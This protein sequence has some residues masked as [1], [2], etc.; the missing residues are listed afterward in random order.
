MEKRE[1]VREGKA[2]RV[3]ATDRP[4]RLILEF[5]DEV[6][7]FGGRKRGVIPGKGKVNAQVSDAVFRHLAKRGIRTHHVELLSENEVLVWKLEMIPLEVAV[8]NYAAGSLAGRL[9]YPERTELRSPLLEY[10]YKNDELGDPLL[11][12]EHIRELGLATDDQLEEMAVTALRVNEI[13][14]PFFEARGLVL[15]DL[16]LEFGLREGRLHLGDELSPDVCRLWDAETGESMDKDRFRRDLGGMEEAYAEVLRR[17]KEEEKGMEVSVFITPKKGVLDP[18]GQATLG[19]LKS[20]GFEEVSDVRI[21]KFITLKM[22]GVEAD[23]ALE[24]VR[25]MC[26]RLLAN[27]IIEDYRVEVQG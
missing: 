11:C 16:K 13:L 22:E 10:Y 25:E 2:K 7:A 4:D 26:E 15:A 6:T 17:V 5:K 3:Y 23:R 12:R 21:G 18:A 27:P 14:R 24:R 20:L 1:L 9:G 19:A 8:R